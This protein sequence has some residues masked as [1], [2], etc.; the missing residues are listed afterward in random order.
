MS[1][2]LASAA[3]NR[4]EHL[5]RRIYATVL[6]VL[7][8][9]LWVNQALQRQHFNF[10]GDIVLGALMLSVLGILL[11]AYLGRANNL[12]LWVHALLGLLA[13]LL[14]PVMSLNA[15]PV[16][17]HTEPWVWWVV[18]VAALSAGVS[19]IRWAFYIYLPVISLTW[20]LVHMSAQGGSASF[21]EAIQ[22][23]VYVLLAAGSISGLVQLV[24][25]WALKVDQA[26]S[27][28]ISSTISGAKADALEREGQRIDALVHDSV[29]HTLIF[30]ATASTAAERKTAGEFAGTAIEKLRTIDDSDLVSANVTP[31]AFFR[32]LRKAALAV[33]PALEVATRDGG[34]EP[35]PSE[36]AQAITEA[37]LQAIDNAMKH[38]KS[39]ELKLNLYAPE[40]GVIEI[41]II[42][43]GRGFKQERVARD[44]IGIRGSIVSRMRIVGGTAT[45]QSSP[46]VGTTVSLRWPK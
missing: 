33:N 45:I 11:S 2:I 21:L 38:A 34:L 30:A 14:L 40:R 29:L 35:I 3:S 12:M 42:D 13:V 23:S 4:L 25:D 5:S 16:T 28:Y 8:V 22:E 32:A 26:N 43:N 41:Q 20:L 44:R 37:T 10:L 27:S 24:R 1:E 15:T 36:A 39:S 7:S 17:G 18:G 6:A 9:E 31:I 46:G 19:G